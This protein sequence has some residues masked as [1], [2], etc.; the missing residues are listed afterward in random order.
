MASYLTTAAGFD[1]WP[2][3]DPEFRHAEA[4]IFDHLVIGLSDEG[5]GKRSMLHKVLRSGIWADGE[6][7]KARPRGHELAVGKQPV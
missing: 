7:A 1:D 6:K 4:T 2:G 5:C 3:R